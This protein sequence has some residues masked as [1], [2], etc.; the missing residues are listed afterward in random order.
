MFILLLIAMRQGLAALRL[1]ELAVG[2]IVETFAQESVEV[3]E[4]RYLG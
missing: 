2:V 3:V 1:A 4:L